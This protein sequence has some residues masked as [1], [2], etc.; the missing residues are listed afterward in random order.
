MTL[1][2]TSKIR[3][4][5]EVNSTDKIIDMRKV[6]VI[7]VIA[8]TTISV[9]FVQ[10]YKRTGP[11]RILD[12]IREATEIRVY[13]SI[14][15]DKAR[16]DSLIYVFPRLRLDDSLT[17]DATTNIS[18]SNKDTVEYVLLQD[19]AT[20]KVFSH[21][22]GN[23]LGE[24]CVPDSEVPPLDNIELAIIYAS[25]SEMIQSDSLYCDSGSW[26]SADFAGEMYQFCQSTDREKV[27]VSGADVSLTMILSEADSG[28]RGSMDQ[29]VAGNLNC[30]SII[31][32][33]SSKIR[34]LRDQQHRRLA[35]DNCEKCQEKPKPCLFFHGAGT[36][37]EEN[38]L[39][40]QYELYWG[41]EV[42]DNMPCCS[43]VKFARFDTS[44]N[45][46]IKDSLQNKYCKVLASISSSNETDSI[47]DVIIVTHSMATLVL[48]LAIDSG[49]CY[50][51]DSSKWAAIQSPMKGSPAADSFSDACPTGDKSDAIVHTILQW[52][53]VCPTHSS[54]NHFYVQGGKKA[55]EAGLNGYYD[56]AQA[57]YR[58][59]V[60]GAMCG[61]SSY[62]ITSPYS[63]KFSAVDSYVDFKSEDNDG[64]VNLD[65][66]IGTLDP[67]LFHTSYTSRFYAAS[68]NHADGTFRTSDGYWG[69]D[70]KPLRWLK[71][72]F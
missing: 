15:R 40:D 20:Y 47:D 7:A 56:R 60:D 62:G 54:F 72:L 66:C 18:L 10:D 22:G 26:Y 37:I 29:S 11:R 55:N 1:N 23:L 32:P 45:A 38:E 34:R 31:S 61:T 16:R 8:I 17:F 69:N 53:G 70:R 59:R 30:R 71:C 43:S 24:G 9:Y 64:I 65:S 68:I 27:F 25:V 21:V 49:K 48:A 57:I 42:Q 28:L 6:L 51:G 19:R 50:L 58:Q 52:A 2:N 63:V 13:T 39:L 44:N 14:A 36:T 67:T 3:K 46:W 41:S 5:F 12:S 4:G 33:R 35:F